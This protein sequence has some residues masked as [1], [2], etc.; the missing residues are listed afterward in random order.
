MPLTLRFVLNVADFDAVVDFHRRLLGFAAVG[1]WERGPDDRGALL[2]V[3]PGGVLEVVGHGP[4]F[5]PPSYDDQAIAVQLADPAEVDAHHRRLVDAGVAV[6][7]PQSRPW[8]HYSMSLRDPAGLEVVLYAEEP[9][10]G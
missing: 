8:G 5:T 7:E 4:A 10:A 1:G 6:G 2:E 9:V 3:S